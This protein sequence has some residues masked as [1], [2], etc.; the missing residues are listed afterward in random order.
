VPA[1]AAAVA[2]GRDGTRCER[3]AGT[4]PEG[5]EVAGRRGGV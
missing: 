4:G 1:E 3:V 2:G 5:A